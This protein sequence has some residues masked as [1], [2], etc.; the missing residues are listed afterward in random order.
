MKIFWKKLRKGSWPKN[1]KKFVRENEKIV[2]KRV[3]SRL[4]TE[5]FL[6]FPTLCDF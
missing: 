3:R 6:Q 5:Y 1:R 4:I 2:K